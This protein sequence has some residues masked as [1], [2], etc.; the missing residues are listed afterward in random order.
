MQSCIKV[1]KRTDNCWKQS[2]RKEQGVERKKEQSETK[3]TR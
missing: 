1:L 2:A 3:A